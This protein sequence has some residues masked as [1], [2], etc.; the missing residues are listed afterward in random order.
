[1]RTERLLVVDDM[2][3][4]RR[5]IGSIAAKSG[6]SVE[7]AGS[8]AEFRTMYENFQPSVIVLD[9]LMPD[10]DGIELLWYLHREGFDGAI[11][12]VSG[13]SKTLHIAAQTMATGLRLC[14]ANSFGKPLNIQEFAGTLMEL[15]GTPTSRTG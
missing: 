11:V 4:M 8:A 10:E 5:L 2:P 15:R 12:I 9:L 6:Y 7:T 3:G 14:V 1:M 13:A